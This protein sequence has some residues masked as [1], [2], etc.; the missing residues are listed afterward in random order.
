MTNW[1]KIAQDSIR[2]SNRAEEVLFLDGDTDDIVSVILHADKLAA[3][4]TQNF[5]PYFR[6]QEHTPGLLGYRSTRATTELIWNF[7]KKNIRYKKDAN[8]HERIKSPGKLWEDKVGDCKSMSIFVASLLRNLNIPYKYRFAH[9]SNPNRPNDQEVNHVFVVAMDE[10]GRE[11]PVDTVTGKFDYEEPYEFAW[12]A[13]IT[14]GQG[15]ASVGDIFGIGAISGTMFMPLI[16][17]FLVVFM[18]AKFSE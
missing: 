12:D 3:P 10:R 18:T 16:A 17:A 1:A 7:V 8:G 11:I 13:D 15:A 5:A 9:Y 6:E 14:S 2:P 4:F